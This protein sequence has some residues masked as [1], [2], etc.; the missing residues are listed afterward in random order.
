MNKLNGKVLKTNLKGES[1][2][3]LKVNQL[4]LENRTLTCNLDLR[5]SK[6]GYYFSS[7]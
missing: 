7:S 4:N 3:Y 1:L 6:L 2:N 5:D